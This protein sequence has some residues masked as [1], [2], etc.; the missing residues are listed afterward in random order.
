MIYP[1]VATAMVTVDEAG[2][3][4]RVS[5]STVTRAFT[6]DRHFRQYGR[7]GVIGLNR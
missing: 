7:I 2:R 6:F 5:R 4:L 1:R 3:A